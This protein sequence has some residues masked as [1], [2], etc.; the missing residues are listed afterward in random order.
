MTRRRLLASTV[1]IGCGRKLATRYFGWMF[2]ASA[3]ERGI[4]VADLSQFRHMTTIG[5]EH[6]P[7]QVLR[8]GEKLFVTCPEA[9][10]LIEIDLGHFKP[11]R[12]LGLPGKIVSAAVTPDGKSMVVLTEQPAEICVV[13]PISLRLKKRTQLAGTPGTMDVI[14]GMAVVGSA[15][16]DSIIRV[17]LP[18]GRVAGTTAVG[19][20]CCVVRFRND[21]NAILAGLADTKQA[22]TKQIVTLDAATGTLVARLPLAFAPARFSFNSDGGQ[23]F[24]TGAGDDTLAIVKPYQSEVDQTIIAGRTPFG[25]AVSFTRNL[26]LVTN[27]GSGDLTILD[28]E[29]RKLRAS[30]HMGGSPGEVL[31][32]PDEEYALVIGRDSG[33]VAVVRM[34]TVL[35]RSVK[36]KPLFTVFPMGANPQSAVIVPVTA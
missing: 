28:I 6:T 17:T 2:V 26:L 8:A 4:A 33:D 34:L 20:N 1:L 29:T 9:R 22:D 32:T 12:K 21:G 10:S 24:V 13:D 5:L 30:V 31:L 27:P 36:T 35:D 23:M 19:L 11:S 3:A 16:G 18:D 15:T 25:M 7:G 14:D